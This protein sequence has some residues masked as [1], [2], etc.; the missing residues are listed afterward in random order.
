MQRAVRADWAGGTG[1][2]ALLRSMP[3]LPPGSS[4]RAAVG[5][6]GGAQPHPVLSAGHGSVHVTDH[7]GRGKGAAGQQ[8]PHAAAK[9]HGNGVQRVV[10]LQGQAGGV[11]DEGR[12]EGGQ[13]GVVVE[14]PPPPLPFPGAGCPA[15]SP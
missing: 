4:A 11:G 13:A 12:G 14:A 2:G 6:A 9:V 8:A 3:A 10:N 5:A 1:Q 7:A 15:S